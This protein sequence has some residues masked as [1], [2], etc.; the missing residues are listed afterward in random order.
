MQTLNTILLP[1]I[2]TGSDPAGLK[3]AYT[4]YAQALPST[5]LWSEEYPKGIRVPWQL[6]AAAAHHPAVR[7]VFRS[8]GLYLFGTDLGVPIYLG[9][10]IGPLWKRLSGRY[11]RGPRSQ[12]KLACDH[13]ADLASRGVDGFPQDVRDWY[14]KNHGNGTARLRGAVEFAR[15]GP[16]RIWFTLLPISD[17]GSVRKLERLLIPIANAW[18]LAHGHSELVN[19]QDI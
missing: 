8:P 18:N 12:C 3:A 1:L 15:R 10:T 17:A 13:C 6:A 4:Q 11:V 7:E 16:E 14:K 9:M 5:P 19:H 2:A